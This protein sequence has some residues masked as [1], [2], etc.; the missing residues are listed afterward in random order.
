MNQKS[1]AILTID[2]ESLIRE[3]FRL[4]LEDCGYQVQEAENGRVGLDMI[5]KSLP[6]LV[7]LD[8]RMPEIDGLDV[9]QEV[10]ENYPDLPI[11]VISGTG[12]IGDAVEAMKRGA[13]SYLLKPIA[14]FNT[15]RHAVEQSLEKARL[16]VENRNCREKLEEKLRLRAQA[17]ERSNQLLRDTRMQVILRLGKAAEFRD[18]GT[19][20]H[21]IRVSCYTKILANCM[22]FS[23]ED[24]DVMA[25]GS[26]LHD[27]GKIGISDS[28]LLKPGKLSPEE[29]EEMKKHCLY[30][31]DL[32]TPLSVEDEEG[33]TSEVGGTLGGIISDSDLLQMSRVVAYSHH[34]HWDGSGYPQG[35]KGDEI[36]VVARIVTAVDI[37]DAIGSKRPYKAPYCEEKC[38]QIMRE[39]SGTILDP[40][41]VKIFFD[42]LDLLQQIK[43]KWAD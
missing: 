42:S 26:A 28:I 40:E 23:E 21:V 30:G 33:F 12:F 2:D 19:G 31:R 16:I 11:I 13:W 34:E 38:L 29:W 5:H 7:L 9:L 27:V 37:Y 25:L 35:L 39:A 8:L 20:R 10:R 1:P 6:D 36:P 15:L 17:L 4:Y 24:A 3:S 43:A 22:G 14:D 41:V 32:L 18:K